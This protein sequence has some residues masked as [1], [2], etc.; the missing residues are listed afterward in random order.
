[1]GMNRRTCLR[2]LASLGA[3]AG[4]LVSWQGRLAAHMQAAS[5]TRR[6]IVLWMPG[7]PSQLDT[8]DLKP[9]H[10]NGGPFKELQTSV[11]GMRFSEHLPQLSKLAEHMA[12]VRGMQTKEGDHSR[13]T[14]LIRTGQRPGSPLQYPAIPAALAKELSGSHTDRPAYVSILPNSFINPPAFSAGFLGTSREPLTVGG[15]TSFDPQQAAEQDE[16]TSGAVDLRVDNLLPPD[17]LLPE[18]VMR[19]K[20]FWEMLQ[21]SYGAARRPGAPATHDTVY[22]RAMQLAESELVEAFDLKHESPAVRERYGHDAFGQ[23]CL[24]ARRLIERDVP[25]VEVSLSEGPGGLAWD[26][27]ADNF[28]TVK[29]LSARLDRGWSQLMLDLHSSG[30]L[31]QTTIVWMGEFGRTPQ[32]NEMG[33]RDHFPGAWSCVLA[34][35]GVA[36]GAIVGKTSSDG[37]EVIDR[38]TTAADFLATVCSAVG[39]DPATE[40]MSPDQRPLKISEGT[41]IAELLAL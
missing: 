12:L 26:S 6:L 14:Y 7:G 39:V 19:R 35:G 41:P 2:T 34:G 28:E 4:T 31:E 29:R 24:L 37:M 5:S 33:G 21:T 25:V 10:A 11:P 8:F 13:G 22:R 23:G 32:I 38:P 17:D 36:G 27:H 40:N 20:Q 9:G 15:T 16:P 1:M 3:G 18:R 30:L